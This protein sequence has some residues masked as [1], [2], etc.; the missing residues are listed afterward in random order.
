M[1]VKNFKMG[2]YLLSIDQ[3]KLIL[4]ESQTEV[5]QSAFSILMHQG[6]GEMFRPSSCLEHGSITVFKLDKMHIKLF[7]GCKNKHSKA[8]PFI[9]KN[10]WSNIHSM[11]FK[12]NCVKYY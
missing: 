7:Y 4:L 3:T 12:Q 2:F 9:Y 6:T 8:F 11:R 10:A 5:T 1:N